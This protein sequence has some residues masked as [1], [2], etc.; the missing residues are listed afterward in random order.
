MVTEASIHY[1]IAD[2]FD[3]IIKGESYGYARPEIADEY[4]I[5]EDVLHVRFTKQHGD[6]S[7]LREREAEKAAAV[8]RVADMAD[9]CAAREREQET[10]E[11]KAIAEFFTTHNHGLGCAVTNAAA[12]YL[13]E[14]R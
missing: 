1:A 4:G 13:K 12:D 8:Q 14:V 7:T 10:A 11:R 3:A 5:K 2:L 9:R 6:W